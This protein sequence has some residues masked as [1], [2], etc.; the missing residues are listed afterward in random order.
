MI[1]A[2][3]GAQP[4]PREFARREPQPAPLLPAEQAWLVPLDALPSA[5][6]ALDEHR[7]YVPLKNAT[8]VALNR[9]TGARI[10]THAIETPWPP[11]LH[12]AVLYVG[13]ADRIHALDAVTGAEQW[14]TTFDDVL[15][16]PLTFDVDSII[17][18]YGGGE[19]VALRGTDG[20]KLWQQNLGDLTRY[21]ATAGE[22]DALY[23]A[24]M[25]S[26]LVALSRR[27]GHRLWN[28]RLPGTLSEPTV[29]RGRV[30]VGSTDNFFY[31]FDSKSGNL[32]WR[33][34][35]GGDVIGAAVDED[36][37]V[38]F[39]SL[40]NILRAVRRG[41]GNQRWKE[42][43]PSRPALPPRAFGRIVVTSGVAPEITAF[44]TKTGENLG[45]YTAPAELEGPPLIDPVLKPY[46]VTF[47]TI[48]RDG[49]AIGLRS[50]RLM[51]PEPKLGPLQPL[52]GR[53]LERE[54]LN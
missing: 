19:V 5:G 39:A 35:S 27:D 47:V 29:A 54:G 45:S 36:D 38:Y 53:R 8:L 33:W 16:A 13:T 44:S 7:V 2:A 10:W 21:A 28:R 14:M 20:Q 3:L 46:R 37:N 50:S 18:V 41:N 49:R 23:F 15:I 17:A 12:G 42:E 40:D 1:S 22:A 9:E 31:A 24:R 26:Q 48:T 34:R 6:G 4:V 25:D 30:F 51:F 43:I 11:L 32:A 52:P